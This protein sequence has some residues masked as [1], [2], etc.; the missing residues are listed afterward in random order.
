MLQSLSLRAELAAVCTEWDRRQI[1]GGLLMV[2]H[3][4]EANGV[5]DD[6]GDGSQQ[7]DIA[8]IVEVTEGAGG[9]AI[10]CLD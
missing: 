5:D 3:H 10:K 7:V 4:E 6:E 9:A 8:H 2:L 1:P